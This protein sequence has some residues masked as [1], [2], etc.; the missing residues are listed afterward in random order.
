L[1]NKTLIID[2]RTSYADLLDFEDPSPTKY[3]NFLTGQISPSRF[4]ILSDFLAALIGAYFNEWVFVAWFGTSLP[5]NI[6]TETYFIIDPLAD[7]PPV[8]FL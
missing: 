4:N 5:I 1:K 6:L 2:N 3:I 8:T 7:M